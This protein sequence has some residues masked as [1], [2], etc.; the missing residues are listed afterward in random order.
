MSAEVYYW[1]NPVASSSMYICS[2]CGAWV[3]GAHNCKSAPP[4]A[5]MDPRLVHELGRIAV[6]LE[7]I[8]ANTV[9][10]ADK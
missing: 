3:T 1:P 10:E 2:V 5:P 6:A 9:R 4:Q 8:A 7:R